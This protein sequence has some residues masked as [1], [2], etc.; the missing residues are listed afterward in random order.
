[1]MNQ[2][3]AHSHS[4]RSTDILGS[5]FPRAWQLS[6]PN[7]PVDLPKITFFLKELRVGQ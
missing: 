4:I 5:L 7:F 3:N 6:Q 2:V 1:M